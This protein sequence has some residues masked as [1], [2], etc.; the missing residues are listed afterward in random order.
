MAPDQRRCHGHDQKRG[1]QQRSDKPLADEFAVKEHGKERAQ[2]RSDQDCAHHNDN[3]V[4]RSFAK[5]L[6]AKRLC[7]VRQPGELE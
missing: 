3:R 2:R 6:V 1:D 5:K 4:Q 7:V